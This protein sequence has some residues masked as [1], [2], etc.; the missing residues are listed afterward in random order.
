MLALYDCSPFFFCFKAFLSF[1]WP[2]LSQE[3][4]II[5]LRRGCFGKI[6]TKSKHWDP[7]RNG[8]KLYIILGEIHVFI[9]F[10]LED[11]IVI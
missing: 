2:R 10:S 7:D 11:F 6:K 3:I 4:F 9:V 1:L 8:I 5:T